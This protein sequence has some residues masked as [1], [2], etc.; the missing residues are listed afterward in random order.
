[1]GIMDRIETS[2]VDA[3]HSV[4]PVAGMDIAAIKGRTK[5]KLA[6]IGNLDC[7]LIH[8]STPERCY[9][10]TLRILRDVRAQEDSGHIFSSCNTIF[11][12]M[13]KENYDAV[14]EARLAYDRE[15]QAL[16]DIPEI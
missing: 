16:S 10:E 5:G 8:L 4:D 6:L 12:G 15:L 3:L 2:G 7:T 14:I 9:D 11:L 1:M 13:P